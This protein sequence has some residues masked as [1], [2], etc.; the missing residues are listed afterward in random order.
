M[1]ATA[2][3]RDTVTVRHQGAGTAGAHTSTVVLLPGE[4]AI[5]GGGAAGAGTTTAKLRDANGNLF[6]I[7]NPAAS[8]A[9]AIPGAYPVT[10]YSPG[11]TLV[12]ATTGA[13]G[14]TDQTFTIGR[15]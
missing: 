5:T 2:I 8:G 12:I 4:H 9:A 11:C 15:V 1:E 14:A 6:D 7:P 13:D 10:F 3:C